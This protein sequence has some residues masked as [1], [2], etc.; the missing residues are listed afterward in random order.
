MNLIMLEL[1]GMAKWSNEETKILEDA[2]I[3]NEGMDF[4]DFIELMMKKVNRS[5]KS[6]SSKMTSDLRIDK[7]LKNYRIVRKNIR[8]NNNI[9]INKTIKKFKLGKNYE[10]NN[11]GKIKNMGLDNWT[12]SAKLISKTDRFAVFDLE[13][14][15]ECFLWNCYGLDWKVNGIR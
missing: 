15:K 12:K 5:K 9:A 10:L 1:C 8:K 3:E 13:S 2:I 6:I 14:R 11:Y 4:K 7:M